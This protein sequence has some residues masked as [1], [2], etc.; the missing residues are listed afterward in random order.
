MGAGPSALGGPFAALGGSRERKAVICVVTSTHFSIGA[1]ERS[2]APRV[3]RHPLGEWEGKLGVVSGGGSREVVGDGACYLR[4]LQ[5]LRLELFLFYRPPEPGALMAVMGPRRLRMLPGRATEAKERRELASGWIPWG[6]R[7]LPDLVSCEMGT[8]LGRG[9]FGQ[10]SPM[11][12]TTDRAQ[13]LKARENL[14]WS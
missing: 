14:V 12:P 9:G 6:G 13:C 4:L 2:D 11:H 10:I 3:F 8:L 5:G 7:D 1:G